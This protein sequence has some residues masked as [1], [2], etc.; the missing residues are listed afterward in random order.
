MDIKIYVLSIAY[1]IT[2]EK[3]HVMNATFRQTE[4]LQLINNS[5]LMYLN[6]IESF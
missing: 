6:P 4:P 5:P 2:N 3:F 1:N